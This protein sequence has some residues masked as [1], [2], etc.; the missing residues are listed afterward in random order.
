MFDK[1]PCELVWGYGESGAAYL[2]K[3]LGAVKLAMASKASDI[4]EDQAGDA[5]VDAV[6]TGSTFEISVPLTRLSVAQLALI[7][8]TP[9]SGNIIPIINQIG[10]SL[11][12]LA[13]VLV[14]KPLCGNIVSQ[15]PATWIELYKTYPVA[16]LDLTFDKETQRI[17]PVTFKVFVSQE[18]GE[19]GEF[20]QIGMGSG[21]TE[22]GI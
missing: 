12:S 11:Y 20:G 10:C 8:N 16:G 1:G 14:I 17:F 2:G 7:L 5:A 4:N 15:D 18:S 6:L 19:E 3:T 22:F 9:A 21:S 13:K